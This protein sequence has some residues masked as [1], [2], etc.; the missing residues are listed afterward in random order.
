MALKAT[1][2]K[3]Q[4]SI[5]DMDRGYYADHALT[6]ARHPS[7]T[8]ERMMLRIT[9]FAL[10]ADA[11]LEFGKGLS[12]EDEPSLWRKSLTGETEQWIEVGL[13]DAKR[14]RRACGRANEML[15]YAYGRAANI[16]WRQAESDL[17]R[18]DNLAI[19]KFD[20]EASLALTVMVE[21]NMK[22]QFTIQDG[23]TLVTSAS[24]SVE[25]EPE[26]LKAK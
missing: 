4:V 11:A 7:E 23:I 20:A 21:R 5:A 26:R 9:A 1:I 15:I 13:P 24:H 3:A 10:N 16:W 19:W 14:V 2:F 8:D 12:D 22:L 6:I 25:V 17:A 18:H